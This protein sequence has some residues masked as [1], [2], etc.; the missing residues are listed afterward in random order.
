MTVFC[1]KNFIFFLK[2]ALKSQAMNVFE[3][4]G[5]VFR[6]RDTDVQHRAG[7]V[8][9]FRA[10]GDTLFFCAS[11]DKAEATLEPHLFQGALAS[12]TLQFRWVYRD[13]QM[14]F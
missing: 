12:L 13:A 11:S 6:F 3:V 9:A 10:D 8:F 4:F 1:A 2:P 5:C 7:I 14:L